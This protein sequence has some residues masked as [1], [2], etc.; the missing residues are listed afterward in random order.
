MFGNDTDKLKLHSLRHEEQIKFWECFLLS[1]E[2]FF[3][4]TS[5]IWKPTDTNKISVLFLVA[6]WARNF[7]T[8]R[9]GNRYVGWG[10]LKN[11]CCEAPDV[12]DGESCRR[13]IAI[14]LVHM[15]K[16][17]RHEKLWNGLQASLNRTYALRVGLFWRQK[18]LFHLSSRS[19]RILCRTVICLYS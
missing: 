1:V 8:C 6:L 15:A 14:P 3:T 10:C 13:L 19:Q 16:K 17:Q 7:V 9:K 2:K 12:R 4:I 11:N 5:P 18:C